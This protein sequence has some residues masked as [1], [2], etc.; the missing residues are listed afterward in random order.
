[1][2][3][4]LIYYMV[5]GA[6]SREGIETPKS[7]GKNW[8]VECKGKSYEQKNVE[9]GPSCATRYSGELGQITSFSYE[10]I[11]SS[12]DLNSVS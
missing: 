6:W 1:M 2:S 8:T 5:P 10:R 3:L 7:A 11:S 4:V 12:M 9:P